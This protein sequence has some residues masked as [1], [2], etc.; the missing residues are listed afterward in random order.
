MGTTPSRN[1]VILDRQT[2][3]YEGQVRG[4]RKDG[5][6]ACTYKV[7][8]G[9]RLDG[10]MYDGE[11]DHDNWHGQGILTWPDGRRYEGNW[12]RNKM[13]GRGLFWA[14]GGNRVFDGIFQ[15]GCPLQGTAIEPDGNLYFAEY[16]GLTNFRPWFTLLDLPDFNYISANRTWIGVVV[17]GGL[18]PH[19]A[20]GAPKEWVA[21][22]AVEDMKL[23]G[24]V[25]IGL[26]PFG[27]VLMVEGTESFKVVYDG[28]VTLAE[29]PKPLCKKVTLTEGVNEAKGEF[30][31]F[32]YLV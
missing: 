18:P 19:G 17:S 16:Y 28:T 26:R 22:L 20:V 1:E 4:L 32:S 30:L 14:P 29:K 8:Y 2:W 24:V 10:A 27:E 3:R 21:S 12:N 5:R 15:M 25:M 13:H 23:E 11:W 7:G 31:L 9:S 6:G